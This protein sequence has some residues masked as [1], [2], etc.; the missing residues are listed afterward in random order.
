M[1]AIVILILAGIGLLVILPTAIS[2]VFALIIPVIIWA[3]VGWLTGK[4]MRGRGYG[5]L[6]NILLGVGGGVL[7]SILFRLLNLQGIGDIWLVGNLIV[8]VV[9]AVVLIYVVRLFSD[10]K[11]FGR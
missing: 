7:G 10:N 5:A 11:A 6:N 3:L 9:G 2:L 1:W 8:G 4:V